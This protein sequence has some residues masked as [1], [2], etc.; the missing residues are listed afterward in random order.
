[1]RKVILFFLLIAFALSTS[2]TSAKSYSSNILLQVRPGFNPEGIIYAKKAQVW[3]NEQKVGGKFSLTESSEPL[4]KE[5][6]LPILNVGDYLKVG[7]SFRDKNN[8]NT[9][10]CERTWTAI[11]TQSIGC[12]P[13]EVYYQAYSNSCVIICN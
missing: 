3:F 10:S 2:I 8:K 4:T 1:M 9:I 13:I 5:V 11:A 12:G 6:K 7:A